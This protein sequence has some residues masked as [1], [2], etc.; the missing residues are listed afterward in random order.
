MLNLIF[1]NEDYVI[2]NLKSIAPL[3]KVITL[4]WCGHSLHTRLWIQ[5]YVVGKDMI[6]GK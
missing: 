1:A 3:G 2:E 5:E 4:D 6:T